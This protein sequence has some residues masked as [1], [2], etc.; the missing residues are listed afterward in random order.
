MAIQGNL[1]VSK[2]G[3]WKFF[4]SGMGCAVAKIAEDENGYVLVY[5]GTMC[6]NLHNPF[7]EKRPTIRPGASTPR[8]FGRSSSG[9]RTVEQ[10]ND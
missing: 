9:P 7:A 5:R 6:A 4:E 8:G 1:Y 3:E 10:K 2:D